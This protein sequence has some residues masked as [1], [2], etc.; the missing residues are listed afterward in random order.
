MLCNHADYTYLC[1][2]YTWTVVLYSI[3]WG[4]GREGAKKILKNEVVFHVHEL[5]EKHAGNSLAC[6]TAAVPATTILG[7]QSM[8]GWGWV[9]SRDPCPPVSE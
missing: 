7:A 1:K 9:G 4:W 3:H 6:S 5:S 8:P 2:A